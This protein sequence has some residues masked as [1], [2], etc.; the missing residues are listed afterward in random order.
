METLQSFIQSNPRPQALKRALAVQMIEKG[1]RYRHIQAILQ[2][3]IG[4]ISSSK[5]R[6]QA[7]GIAGLRVNYWGTQG[8]LSAQ[9][10]EAVLSWM[11]H[12]EVWTIEEVMEHLESEYNVVYRSRQSY[13]TLMAQAGF[14]WKKA[15]PGNPLKDETQVAQKNR[16]SS[17][18]WYAIKPTSPVANSKCCF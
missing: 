3:S 2:V 9:H 8:Y 5:Q 14:S 13:Y 10:K 6:Y 11:G 17:T 7:Q 4:F 12:K 16:K 15:Q 1:H 18:Y